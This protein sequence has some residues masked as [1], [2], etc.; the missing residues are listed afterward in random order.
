MKN[1][2]SMA[3]PSLDG[4]PR[5]QSR[6][7]LLAALALGL[8]LSIR[9]L[10]RVECWQDEANEILICWGSFGGMLESILEGELRP[11]LR[12]LLL[13]VWLRI[14]QDELWLRFLSLIFFA[15]AVLVGQ[16]LAARLFG[17][18]V[19]VASGYLVATSPILVSA[20]T[21]VRSYSLDTFVTL[22][23]LEAFVRLRQEGSRGTWIRYALTSFAALY[24]SYYFA[25]VLV[26]ETAVVLAAGSPKTVI[27]RWILSQ[28]V[29]AVAFVPWLPVMLAQYLNARSHHWPPAAPDAYS[30]LGLLKSFSLGR[31]TAST[32]GSPATTWV[33]LVFLASVLFGWVEC[34]RRRDGFRSRDLVL[35]AAT[36]L[37]IAVVYGLS[38]AFHSVFHLRALVLYAPLFLLTVARG[39]AALRPRIVGIAAVILAMVAGTAKLVSTEDMRFMTQGIA[40]AEN[41]LASRARPEDVILHPSHFDYFPARYY[42]GGRANPPRFIYAPRVPWNWGA[43]QVPEEVLATDLAALAARA[44]RVWRLTIDPVDR[45]FARIYRDHVD[46]VSFYPPMPATPWGR[47]PVLRERFG[48]IVVECFDLPPS[49]R[50]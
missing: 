12:Y 33:S 24:T 46:D 45:D 18:S 23:A 48:N 26:A 49:E 36:L 14:S 41:F 27:K 25:F 42:G 11:P 21:M 13:W 15:G 32:S 29:L 50:D 20:G 34:V 10:A 43:T 4:E 35:A 5:L 19:A 40:E 38:L 47:A 37:P 39:A 16:R 30:L 28:I 22:L 3:L 8:V 7:H 2:P 31:I 17:H 44:R 6:L 9:D 1:K